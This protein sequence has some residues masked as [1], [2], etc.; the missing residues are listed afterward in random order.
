[1]KILLI[2]D[3]P[4]TEECMQAGLSALNRTNLVYAYNLTREFKKRGVDVA[5]A[6]CLLPTRNC[7]RGMVNEAETVSFY[8]NLVIPKCDHVICLDQ[9]GFYLR[10]RAFYDSIRRQCDGVIAT[11][12]DHDLDLGPEDLLFHA[13]RGVSGSPQSIYVG[14]AADAELFYPEKDPQVL[15]IFVDH[16]YYVEEKYDQTQQLIAEATRFARA[17]EAGHYG[18]AGDKRKARVTFF[19]PKGLEILD[20]NLEAY[21]DLGS[22]INIFYKRAPQEDL[23]KAYRQTDI[24]IVTHREGAGQ[25]MLEN[26]LAGA[27]PLVK[28]GFIEPELL[29]PLHHVE[30]EF[31]IPW[32]KVVTAINPDLSV[33]KAKPHNW[34]SVAE[35]MLNAI[36]KKSALATIPQENASV[37]NPPINYFYNPVLQAREWRLAEIS[38]GEAR[39]LSD[40]SPIWMMPLYP[41][42]KKAYHYIQRRIRKSPWPV[43][44]ALS[45][46]V[47]PLAG[48]KFGVWLFGHDHSAR[49]Q[50]SFDLETGRI[51]QY[52]GRGG[53]EVNEA[54]L[55][56]LKDGVFACTVLAQTDYSPIAGCSV[57]TIAEADSFEGTEEAFLEIGALRLDSRL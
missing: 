45:V 48:K 13:R 23:I 12:C 25:S 10:H 5:Y 41:S 4:D 44:L 55:T 2:T 46:L 26:A 50:V 24:Y 43:P 18:F 29:Y 35:K 6:H 30:Y 49:A 1:M 21:P 51:I 54:S 37:V 42:R 47:R 52:F 8:E 33:A 36:E 27:L 40:S 53:W 15:N 32:R 19:G 28:K 3:R 20:N 34:E 9:K 14:W 56:P 11:L 31:D 22:D 39:P 38:L 16:K 57:T 17:Y 7:E